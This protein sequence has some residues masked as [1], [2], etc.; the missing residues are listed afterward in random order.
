MTDQ[1][2]RIAVAEARGWKWVKGTGWMFR[3]KLTH[4]PAHFEGKLKNYC[5]ILP[6]YPNDLNVCVAFE[7]TLS[8]HGQIK[9]VEALAEIILSPE[10]KRHGKRWLGQEDKF[11]FMTT[12]TARQRCEAFLRVKGLW[13]DGV[14]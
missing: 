10:L 14:K 9:Y 4:T 7:N 12:A 5:D 13:K 3:S 8:I 6:N 2:I 11:W 1:E